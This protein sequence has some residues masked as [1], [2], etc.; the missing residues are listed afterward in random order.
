MVEKPGIKALLGEKHRI[1]ALS[2]GK[3]EGRYDKKG[4][5]RRTLCMLENSCRRGILMELIDYTVGP[6]M[7]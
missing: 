5:W 3:L 4:Y 7:Q 2:T 1:E 6:Y